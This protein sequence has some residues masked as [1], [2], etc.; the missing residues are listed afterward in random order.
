MVGGAL[1]RRQRTVNPP[2]APAR[3]NLLHSSLRPALRAERYDGN[4]EAGLILQPS[5][6]IFMV[7]GGLSSVVAG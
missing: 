2:N 1:L 4:D 7:L 3:Y 6:V 5:I